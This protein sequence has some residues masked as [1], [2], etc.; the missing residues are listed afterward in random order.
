MGD[1]LKAE[2]GAIKA[3]LKLRQLGNVGRDPP[4]L[5]VSNF[6][7]DLRPGSSSK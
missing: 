1:I 4:R 6:A 2:P 5:R 7:A 3:A